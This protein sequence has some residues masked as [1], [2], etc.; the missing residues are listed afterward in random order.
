VYPVPFVEEEDT[1]FLSMIIA[2]RKTTKKY[3]GEESD[4]E[5]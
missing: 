3:I 2:S 1:V 5:A 4:N